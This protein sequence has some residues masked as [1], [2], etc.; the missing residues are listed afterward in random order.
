MYY[1][2]HNTNHT[3][4]LFWFFNFV[5]MYNYGGRRIRKQ[6]GNSGSNYKVVTDSI[7]VYVL[8]FSIAVP[9]YCFQAFAFL[10]AP[11][12]PREWF[13][14]AIG[15]YVCL[16]GVIYVNLRYIAIT[17]RKRLHKDDKKKK[18]KKAKAA[19]SPSSV[20]QGTTKRSTASNGLG[21]SSASTSMKS[22]SNQKTST[23]ISNQSSS[24][25]HR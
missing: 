18:R 4:S 25:I 21:M 12:D 3:L 11:Y 17:L 19:V 1:N 14:W 8:T 16:N 24:G 20:T 13:F 22:S 2:T 5:W 23:G 7:K 15:C 10:M 6:L 9:M